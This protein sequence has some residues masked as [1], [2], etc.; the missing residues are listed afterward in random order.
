MDL[1]LGE[2]ANFNKSK[3]DL[4]VNKGEVASNKLSNAVEV[5]NKS[6]QKLEDRLNGKYSEELDLIKNQ[7]KMAV[8][9]IES[10]QNKFN[11]V[12]TSE[13]SVKLIK[14]AH[15]DMKDAHTELRKTRD[16]LLD[17]INKIKEES[18]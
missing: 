10:A 8:D 11:E 9:K 5:F 14:E 13:D 6:I 17:L 12:K 15:K 4:I 16:M 2:L 3:K 1:S 7:Y 18:K